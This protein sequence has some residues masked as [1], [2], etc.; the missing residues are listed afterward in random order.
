MDKS[1]FIDAPR[2]ALFRM[3]KPF[4]FLD[5]DTIAIESFDDLFE[6]LHTADDSSNNIYA[7]PNFRNKKRNYNDNSGNFNAGVMVVPNPSMKGKR[8]V[9]FSYDGM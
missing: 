3:G 2:R 5:A 9:T 8:R 4:I 1:S 6:L 7:V